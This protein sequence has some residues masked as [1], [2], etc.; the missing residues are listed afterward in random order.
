VLGKKTK[1]GAYFRVLT[2]GERQGRMSKSALELSDGGAFNQVQ[3]SLTTN[4]RTIMEA[5]PW[6]FVAKRRQV[7]TPMLWYRIDSL[8]RVARCNG[9]G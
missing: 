7:L 4:L 8:A 2:C 5:F 9:P 1:F 6:D 3:C